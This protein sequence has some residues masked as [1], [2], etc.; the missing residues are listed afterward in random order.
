MVNFQDLFKIISI[1][2][3]KNKINN[4]K[5]SYD[6]S[7]ILSYIYKTFSRFLLTCLFN[8]ISNFLLFD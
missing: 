1:F 3:I 7:N 6:N 8:S 4:K 2:K 5:I